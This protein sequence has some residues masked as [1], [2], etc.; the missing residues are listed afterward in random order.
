[1]APA[2]EIINKK[3]FTLPAKLFQI[4]SLLQEIFG[5]AH[6]LQIARNY[7]DNVP[8]LVQTLEEIYPHLNK[9]SIKNRI[10]RL[11]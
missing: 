5:K 9:R 8:T 6:P 3:S 11:C 4:K 1:M 10:Q 7:T 2:E